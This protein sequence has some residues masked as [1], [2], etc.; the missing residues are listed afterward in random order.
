MRRAAEEIAKRAG[1]LLRDALDKQ[2]R[3]DTKSSAVDLV[4]SADHAAEHLIKSEINQRFPGHDILAE[5]SGSSGSSA[6]VRWI[7]DPL[8]GTVNFAHRIPH[9]CVLIAVQERRAAGFETIV[10]VTY[11]PMRDELF[12]AERGA[13]AVL[14]GAPMRVSSAERLLDSTLATGFGYKRLFLEDDNHREFC[15]LNLVSRGVR[16]MGSA[17]LDIAY[18]ACGRFDGFWESYLNPWDLAAGDLLVREA[19]GTMSDRDGTPLSLDRGTCAGTNGRI[20]TALLAA[21]ASA[22]AHPANSRADLGAHLPADI[23]AE[24]LRSAPK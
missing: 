15:R 8:D 4:T 19:G 23:A 12:V 21:L 16:R 18:V 3:I 14:N 7:V 20:H 1:L 10:G 13:G 9:F 6:D 24:L 22:R 2:N 17:G 5:E 11:D